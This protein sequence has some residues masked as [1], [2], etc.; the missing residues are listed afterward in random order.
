MR[1]RVFAAVFGLMITIPFALARAQ[2]SG[3]SIDVQQAVE[4]YERATSTKLEGISDD[5]SS[6]HLVYS[7]PAEGTASFNSVTRDA[8]YWHQQIRRAVAVSAASANSRDLRGRRTL[9]MRRIQRDWSYSLG[10]QA[11]EGE[12]MFPAKFS[13]SL[14]DAYCDSDPNPDYVAYTTSLAG[15]SSQPNIVAF[16]NLYSGCSGTSP[17]IY[18]AYNTGGGAVRTS[19]TIAI[20]GS[21]LAFVETSRANHAILRILKWAKSQGS[22]SRG[23]WSASGV[24]QSVASWSACGSGSCMVSL[25]FSGSAQDTSSSPFYDWLHDVIY[26]GDNSGVLHKF[27]PVFTGTPVEITTGGWPV[28]VHSG[29]SLTSPAFD[30]NSGNIFVGDSIGRIS[31]VRES[32]STTGTCAAGSP[33]CLGATSIALGGTIVDGPLV[34]ASTEKVFWFD[35]NDIETSRTDSVV[36][37]DVA[38][39]SKVSITFPNGGGDS[40]GNIHLGAFDAAYLDDPASGHLYVCS[41]RNGVANVPSL[42]SIGFSDSPAAG[43]MNNNV[44]SGPLGLAT[45]TRRNACS[46]ITEILNPRSVGDAHTTAGSATLT[47]STALFTNA[48]VG[49][50]ITGTNIP[51]NTTISKVNSSSSV[52]L[53]Q[54]ATGTSTAG[55]ATIDTDWMFLGV[56]TNGSMTG[57]SGACLYSFSVANAFPSGSHSGL[58]SAGGTS[59]IIIDNIAVAPSGTSQIYFTPLSNQI[60]ATS[61]GSGGCAIQASQSGLN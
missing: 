40:D 10:N 4:G 59:G 56:Q 32:V 9:P 33:P 31:Y 12:G 54:N 45:N 47:S 5:W 26:V 60:C 61:G 49:S 20:D 24:D 57:C 16:D 44:A 19:P 11:T 7:R 36:Q 41:Q 2:S 39:G 27:A 18:F 14:T 23:V 53:S 43:T 58:A 37:T 28:T 46:P 6:H 29:A 22:F 34:D 55:T 1:T 8:R 51:A 35:A 3:D 52:A 17:L 25:P 38:L 30:P 13:F 42:Y 15:S 21:K 48:D 50:A